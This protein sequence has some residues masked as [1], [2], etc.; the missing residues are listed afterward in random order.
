MYPF[1]LPLLFMEG[2][3]KRQDRS[4]IVLSNEGGALEAAYF[5]SHEYPLRLPRNILYSA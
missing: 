4:R 2:L 3:V 1:G 5:W